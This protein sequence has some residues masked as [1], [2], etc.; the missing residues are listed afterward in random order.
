M[1]ET[2]LISESFSFGVFRTE[3]NLGEI[4]SEHR[5]YILDFYRTAQPERHHR[6]YE[7]YVV[8]QTSQI[9]PR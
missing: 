1:I 5:A 8:P 9:R 7:I 4:T 6:T 3:R 2:M